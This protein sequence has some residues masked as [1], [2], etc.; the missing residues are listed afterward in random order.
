[1]NCANRLA[2]LE[3]ALCPAVTQGPYRPEDKAPFDYDGF[4]RV[5][6]E[7]MEGADPAGFFS[8]GDDDGD[9]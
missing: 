6:T 1:M 9:A 5:W 2:Q 7:M 8:E 3:R 4:A